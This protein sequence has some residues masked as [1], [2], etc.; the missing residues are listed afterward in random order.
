MLY[1]LFIFEFVLFLQAFILSNKD[2]L[3]PTCTMSIVFIISTF[4]CILN[5]DNWNINFSIETTLIIILG[6]LSFFLAELS[7]IWRYRYKKLCYYNLKKLIANDFSPIDF[8]LTVI[9][10]L[11]IVNIA[12]SVWYYQEITRIVGAYNFFSGNILHSFRV[13][14]T[15]EQFSGESI[16]FFLNQILKFVKG[17]S[18]ALL[19]IFIRNMFVGSIHKKKNIVLLLTLIAS[20]VPTILTGARGGILQLLSAA[21][22]F[23][24]IVW[25]QKLGWDRNLSYKFLKWSILALIVFAPIFYFSTFWIG[26]TINT[27][28]FSYLSIYVGSGIEGF[29]LY[30]GDR[31]STPRY[32]GEETFLGLR[33]VLQS[34]GLAGYVGT[35]FLEV[36]SMNGHLTNIYTF[37]RRP[38]HDFGLLGMCIFTFLV[39]FLLSIIYYKEVKF[40]DYRKNTTYVLTYG[41]LYYWIIYSSLEQWS[42][43]IISLTMLMPIFFM[44][45]TYNILRFIKIKIV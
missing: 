21:A 4:A 28:L 42:Q 10:L 5:I 24:Y 34:W 3:A 33:G 23:I 27:E 31:V 22:I 29:N 12:T 45:F 17:E 38:D 18:Y 35:P 9:M 36:R 30:V 40:G 44:I 25:H 13:V 37:F 39:S 32:F 11:F 16:N 2:I 7:I 14:S 8:S 26:R 1:V 20:I 19:Y 15:N 6:L 43:T 41:Y